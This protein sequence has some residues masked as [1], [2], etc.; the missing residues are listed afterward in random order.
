M[1]EFNQFIEQITKESETQID[2]IVSAEYP[3]VLAELALVVFETE[4]TEPTNRNWAP[5]SDKLVKRVGVLGKFHRNID[6]GELMNKLSTPGFLLNDS[7]FE[8]LPEEYKYANE[9]AP[10]DNIGK[11]VDDQKYIEE[12]LEKILEQR[13]NG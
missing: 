7:W 2:E 9:A 4:G 6:T 12:E 3:F 5:N 11:T 8:S 1:D 10:F 13:I